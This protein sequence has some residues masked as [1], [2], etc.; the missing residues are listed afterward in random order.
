MNDFVA[1]DEDVNKSNGLEMEMERFR[2]ESTQTIVI[3]YA[4]YTDT[5]WHHLCFTHVWGSGKYL[6]KSRKKSKLN[7]AHIHLAVG[8]RHKRSKCNFS[9]HSLS[10]AHGH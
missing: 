4:D 10:V 5:H 2:N 8:L 7:E 9:L 1:E 3:V 6:V